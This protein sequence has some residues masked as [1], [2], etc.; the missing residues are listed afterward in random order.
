MAGTQH[1]TL[2]WRASKV[3][4]QM[5]I[6][7]DFLVTSDWKVDHKVDQKVRGSSLSTRDIEKEESR[8]VASTLPTV[9]FAVV[10]NQVVL[11]E[12]LGSRW[13]QT[14]QGIDVAR[15]VALRRLSGAS[16]TTSPSARGAW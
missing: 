2:L 1:S 3:H 8:E 10:N 4:L 6:P 13:R 5:T 11:S 9:N 12:E 15:E 7:Q 14:Y 16:P